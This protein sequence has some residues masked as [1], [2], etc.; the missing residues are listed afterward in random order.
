MFQGAVAAAPAPRQPEPTLQREHMSET[1]I[2]LDPTA[3]A[4][5]APQRLRRSI[6]S[7]Q[8]KVIG[9]IDNAKPN[10][11]LL[12]DEV[13]ELLTSRYGVRSIVRH[14]KRGASIPAPVQMVDEISSE[15]DLV[16]TGSGD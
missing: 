14:R 9:F 13:A 15:C 2:V 3:S 16:I 12:L 10:F 4:G 11:H 1:I 5:K 7:V 8:G 6:D